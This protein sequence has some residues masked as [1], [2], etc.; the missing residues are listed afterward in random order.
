MHSL[1]SFNPDAADI[2]GEIKNR[3]PIVLTRDMSKAREWL[4]KQVRG[5]QRTGVLVT[6]TCHLVLVAVCASILKIISKPLVG[7]RFLGFIKN[8]NV[9][10]FAITRF[11]H[12]HCLLGINFEDSIFNRV[13][14]LCEHVVA[15]TMDNLNE[16]SNLST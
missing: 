14:D 16:L 1:L 6:K 15:V 11:C 2:Y 9:L 12:L 13:L 8:F 5:T 4:R 10:H 7:L 3:Y